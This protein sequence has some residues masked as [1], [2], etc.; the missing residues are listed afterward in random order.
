MEEIHLFSSA[1]PISCPATFTAAW[2]WSSLFSTRNS[3]ASS[4]RSLFPLMRAIIEKPEFWDRMA[5]PPAPPY[6]KTLPPAVSKTSSFSAT[7][8]T[9]AK[10]HRSPPPYAPPLHPPFPQTLKLSPAY[11][12]DSPNPNLNASPPPPGSFRSSPYPLGRSSPS[13]SQSWPPP[14]SYLPPR[15]LSVSPVHEAF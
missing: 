4:S 12:R 8:Q 9:L 7:P 3:V 14:N 13:S 2:K 10:S 15:P 11:F 5:F 1:A 6:P